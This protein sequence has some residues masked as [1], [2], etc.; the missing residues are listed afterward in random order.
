MAFRYRYCGKLLGGVVVPDV[1]PLNPGEEF[2]TAYELADP[3]A[4]VLLDATLYRNARHGVSVVTRNT[5]ERLNELSIA[6]CDKD[7]CTPR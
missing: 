3:E 7:Y 6:E 5:T 1:G 2:V 4:A